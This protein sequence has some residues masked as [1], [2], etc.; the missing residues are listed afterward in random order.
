MAI[1]NLKLDLYESRESVPLQTFLPGVYTQKL[2]CRGNSI[3]STVFLHTIDSGASVKVEY[4]E[5]T[6]GEDE[7][8]EIPL[9]TH[10]ILTSAPQSSKILVT[11]M[12]NKPNVRITVTGGEARLGVYIT[13]VASFASEL[14]SSLL[15]EGEAFDPEKIKGLMISGVEDSTNEVQ[16]FHFKNG[17]LQVETTEPVGSDSINEFDETSIAAA[18]TQDVLS[19]EVPVGKSLFLCAIDCEGDNIATYRIYREGELIA[20]RST[21]FWSDDGFIDFRSK[22]N[23]GQKILTGETVRVEVENFRNSAANFSARLIGVLINES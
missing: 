22:N 19:Y 8:E 11:R 5:A 14:D 13:V 18:T 15:F 17:K 12:H 20:K 6:T 7:G 10:P 1:D 2:E 3:L 23:G 16:F 9:E 4:I 21:C